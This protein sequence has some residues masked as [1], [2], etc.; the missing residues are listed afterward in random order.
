MM[1]RAFATAAWVFDDG[2]YAEVG[3]T[4]ARFVREHLYRDG[5]LLRTWKDGQAKLNGYLEDYANF[6]DGLL[7]LVRSVPAAG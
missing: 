2:Q 4:N 5:K 7:A 1:L 3:R 6:V